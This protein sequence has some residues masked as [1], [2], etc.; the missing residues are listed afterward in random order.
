MKNILVSIIKHILK[1]TYHNAILVCFT[2]NKINPII[3]EI[4]TDK[5]VIKI[6]YNYFKQIQVHQIPIFIMLKTGNVT[7]T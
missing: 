6:D 2:T 7:W 1:W 5:N 4:I 3:S